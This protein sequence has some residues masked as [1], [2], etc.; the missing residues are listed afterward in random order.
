MNYK[1]FVRLFLFV[2]LLGMFSVACV[3]V[4]IDPF[5]HYH[6]PRPEFYYN[7]NHQRCQNNGILKHFDY[8]AIVTGTSMTENFKTSEF[9][10]LFNVQAVKVPYSGGSFKE[11]NNA[12]AV[13]YKNGH[14]VKA[15]VRALDG[16]GIVR[17]KNAMRTDLGAYPEYLYNDNVFDDLNYIFNKDVLEKRCLPMLE[18]N[19][20]GLKGGI[21]SFDV[22]SNWNKRYKF[23]RQYV[24]KNKLVVNLNKKQYMLPGE[25]MILAKENIQQNIVSLARKHPETIFYY[26]FPPYSI[27]YY[28]NLINKGRLE[29]WISAE[30]LAIEM[31]LECPNI[32]LYSFNLMS[33]ITTNLDNY[34]DATHYGEWINSDILRYMKEGKGLLTKENYQEYLLKERELYMNYP[35]DSI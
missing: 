11:I 31:I 33:D 14:K 13:A 6:K 21:K 5:F 7:L 12:I 15:V 4:Y 29:Q 24:I 32:K 22:Y 25:K 9:N 10:K 26:F 30:K 8:D 3:V 17:D 19:L 2:I 20:K 23:G 27:V 28:G 18:R 1:K 16:Y 34:K 35:Y